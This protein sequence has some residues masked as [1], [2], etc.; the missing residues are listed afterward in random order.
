MFP[1][2]NISKAEFVKNRLFISRIVLFLQEI[3]KKKMHSN[4]FTRIRMKTTHIILCKI[5]NKMLIYI[6]IFNDHLDRSIWIF[7][8][9]PMR[10]IMIKITDLPFLTHTMERGPRNSLD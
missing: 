6:M 10:Y 2:K 9:L 8:S 5:F 3:G 1:F 4:T 7:P